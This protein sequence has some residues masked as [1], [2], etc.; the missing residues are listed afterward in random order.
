MRKKGGAGRPAGPHAFPEVLTAAQGG[1]PWA[2]EVLYRAH[3]PALLRYLR[4]RLPATAED[5]ASQV[6]LEVAGA[7]PRFSG[8]EQAFCG[9]LF[10][11]AGRRLANERRRMGRRKED[12]S[13]VSPE[14]PPAPDVES[15]VL[16]RM[17]GDAAAAL[18]VDLLP[19]A[20]ADVV[21]LRVLGGL[22]VD[23]VAAA[24]GRRPGT[25]RVLQHRALKRLAEHLGGD[26]RLSD[27]HR[28]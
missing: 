19:A 5:L 2:V 12:S 10:T 24:L 20:Q 3:H 23:E 22:D 17:D 27:P 6:W 15:T 7:L 21:L 9:F 26:D 4:A 8:D 11:V 13:A 25:V 16:D 28:L 1:A 18:V 14:P